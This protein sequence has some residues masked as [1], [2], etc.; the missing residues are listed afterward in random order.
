VFSAVISFSFFVI[1]YRF[2]NRTAS[3]MAESKVL[4]VQAT[5]AGALMVI[6]FDCVDPAHLPL[7][8]LQWICIYLYVFKKYSSGSIIHQS[9]AS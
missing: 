1:A 6:T 2:Y 4:G 3:I 9:P 7:T 8:H 5:T